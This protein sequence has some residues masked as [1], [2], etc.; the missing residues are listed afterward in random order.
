MASKWK[1]SY[2]PELSSVLFGRNGPAMVTVNLTNRCDQHCIYC[3]IGQGI[4]LPKKDVL[5]VDD[6]K[7]IIDEMALNHIPKISLCGGEPFL[8]SG[9]IDIVRYAASRNVR[10]SIT[11]NGMTVHQLRAEEL[12]ALQASR[13]E[14]NVSIDSFDEKIQVLTRGRESALSNALK[15][16][17]RLKEYKIPITILTA[18]SKYNFLDLSGFVKQASEKGIRQVLFQPLIFTTNY[19]GQPPVSQ[20]PL[21]NVAPDQLNILKA[22]LIKI[23]HYERNHPVKTNVYRILPWIEHYI[24]AAYGQNGHMFFN[25]VLKKFY[26]REVDAIIDISFDGG[27]QPCGLARAHVNIFD[28]REKGL[29]TIWK[30]ATEGLKQQLEKEQFPDICNSCCHH[31]SRNMISSVMK[32]PFKNRAALMKMLPLFGNRLFNGFRKKIIFGNV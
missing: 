11:T 8:F 29:V 13:V 32:Y 25:N 22:E 6:M 5:T 15:S 24:R 23:L 16:I 21:M 27:I 28:D 1:N 4:E 10:C 18:I 12:A 20:K 19:P 3:E 30:Q 14:I 31:F 17:S 2:L 9:I 7:W 26:C